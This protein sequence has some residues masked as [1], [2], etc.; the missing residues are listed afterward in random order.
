MSPSYV[1]YIIGSTMIHSSLK[2]LITY[3]LCPCSSI[4][5][6]IDPAAG[7]LGAGAG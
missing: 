5:A 3:A 6:T 4:E 1:A 7:T 2:Q